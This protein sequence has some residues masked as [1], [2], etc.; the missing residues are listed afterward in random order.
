MSRVEKELLTLPEHLR[1]SRFLA[2][3][4]YVGP[5]VY[6]LQ[7]TVKLL[8]FPIFRH[9]AYM[10]NVIPEMLRV[11]SIIYLHIYWITLNC[12]RNHT[13]IVIM[14]FVKIN[15]S[16]DS[17]HILAPFHFEIKNDVLVVSF[18]WCITPIWLWWFFV[19][20]FCILTYCVHHPQF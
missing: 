19:V 1:S 15:D 18:L 4:S 3:L 12:C 7:T 14:P 20:L 13:Y 10:M 5:F 11:H 8:G 6:M 17:Q 2:W 9:W 16:S